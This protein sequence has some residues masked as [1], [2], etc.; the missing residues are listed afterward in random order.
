[1]YYLGGLTQNDQTGPTKLGIFQ[2]AKKYNMA[3]VFPD[4]SA[5]GVEIE[6]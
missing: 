3:I 2:H 5:R 4:T 1:M 6:G